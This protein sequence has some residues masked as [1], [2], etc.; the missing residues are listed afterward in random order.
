MY[1]KGMTR[2]SSVASSVDPISL[3]LLGDEDNATIS[4]PHSTY[5]RNES[6]ISASTPL[7]VK[8]FRYWTAKG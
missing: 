7:P 5:H 4:F 6:R 3:S 2:R 8:D 1:E